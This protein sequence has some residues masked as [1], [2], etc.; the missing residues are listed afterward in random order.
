MFRCLL[1]AL[2]A[3]LCVSPVHAAHPLGKHLTR[4]FYQDDESKTVK[5]ADLLAGQSLAL[6]K[7]EVVE[8]FPK[9]DP[10]TQSLAQMQIAQGQLLVAVR[11]NADGKIQSGWVLIDCGIE[12]RPHGNHLDWVYAR[13]PRVKTTQLGTEQGNPPH[14]YVYENQFFV[15][16][17]ERN[18]FTRIDPATQKSQFFSGGGG[19]ISLAVMGDLGLASWIDRDGPNAGRVDLLS[20][21]DPQVARSLTLPHGGI[22]GATVAAQK[23]FFA[24]AEGISWLGIAKADTLAPQQIDLGKIGE[25][26]RRTGHFSTLGHHVGF[27]S[28]TGPET[29]F[30][31]LDASQTPP[32]LT[33]LAVPMAAGTKPG[34]LEL[35]KP[36]RG[37][38]VAL[39]FHETEGDAAGRSRMSLLELNPNGDQKWDDLRV[40][41][42]LTVGKPKIAGH[43]GHHSVAVDSDQ[44]RCI[45]SNPGD[46]T[47]T[48]FSL[49]E[50]K[51]I[52]NYTVG[53]IPTRV[54]AY[55]GHVH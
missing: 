30:G 20:L 35:I 8:G 17:D 50:R 12:T 4:V 47:L 18:G 37:N 53:G 33:K 31:L 23:A 19:H 54:I 2:L 48:V 41:P 11:D 26:P 32:T 43:S 7:P 52:M 45:L 29:E 34:G 13:S 10:A 49:N 3:C 5:W 15:T 46:G 6:A 28:G 38:A 22:H 27:V 25:T 51:L 42:E 40:G 36:R 9:L 16:Q 55:G 39:V 21:S 44:F 1:L 24:T 14:V